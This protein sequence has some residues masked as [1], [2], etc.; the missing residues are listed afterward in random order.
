M[1]HMRETAG[2]LRAVEILPARPESEPVVGNECRQVESPCFNPLL[3]ELWPGV[4]G[5]LRTLLDLCEQTMPFVPKF[6]LQF[7]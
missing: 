3:S 5:N 4:L 6:V 7:T 1:R 2:E